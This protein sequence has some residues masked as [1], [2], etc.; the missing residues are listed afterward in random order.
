MAILKS[1]VSTRKFV[2]MIWMKAL[3]QPIRDWLKQKLKSNSVINRAKAVNRQVLMAIQMLIMENH[4]V[5]W[6]MMILD[7]VAYNRTMNNGLMINILWHNKDR[8]VQIQPEIPQA[9][10]ILKDNAANHQKIIKHLNHALA[11]CAL[12]F[13]QMFQIYG[14]TCD[15][16]IIQRQFVAPSVKSHL[17]QIYTSSVIT[18]PCTA[19]RFPHQAHHKVI[20]THLNY[21]VH[22]HHR[23]DNR[24]KANRC[25]SFSV[26]NFVLSN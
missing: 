17:H 15:S 1:H 12:G 13:I 26:L 9:M 20:Q 7:R 16:Y 10:T 18:Y 25:I 4:T 21:K 8:T 11:H 5:A 23:K 2:W 24:L 19:V 14:N 6:H 3:R 22:S